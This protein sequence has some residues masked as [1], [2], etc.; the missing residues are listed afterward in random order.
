VQESY[1][2]GFRNADLSVLETH[3]RAH[4]LKFPMMVARLASLVAAGRA[5]SDVL[6]PLCF[7]NVGSP[8]PDDWVHEHALL[9][10]G[11]RRGGFTADQV[12]CTS[13]ARAAEDRRPSANGAYALSCV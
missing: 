7:A 4:R 11:V 10:A 6:E 9:L 13:S 3:C 2:L 1:L 8:P 12:Q 5:R